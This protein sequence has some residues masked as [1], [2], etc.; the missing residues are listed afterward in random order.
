MDSPEVKDGWINF[1]LWKGDQAPGRIA[2]SMDLTL[3]RTTR[4]GWQASTNL[5]Q[6][7]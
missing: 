7:V 3:K 5:S 4:N 2:S 6:N 1:P